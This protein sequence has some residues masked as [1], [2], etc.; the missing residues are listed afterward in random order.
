MITG[1][2]AT[3]VF[4]SLA[5]TKDEPQ[6]KNLKVLPKNITKQQMDSVMHQFTGSLGVKCNYCH[7]YNADTKKLDFASDANKKK[8]VARSMMKMTAKINKKYFDVAGRQS[9]DSKLLVGCYTC[10]HG[11]E[12]PTVY[13]P[14][15][16]GPM[17]GPPPRPQAAAGADTTKQQ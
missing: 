1:L 8:L 3:M 5:F 15:V 6:Y 9:L 11:Q 7:Q 16:E 12:E 2:F 10:H 13:A 4:A 14:H 17:Q